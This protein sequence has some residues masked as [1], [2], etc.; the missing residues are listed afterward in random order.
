MMI[1]RIDSTVLILSDEAADGVG[2]EYHRAGTT[3]PG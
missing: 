2:S 3:V 1:E